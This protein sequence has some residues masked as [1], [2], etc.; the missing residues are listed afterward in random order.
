M[1]SGCL[2]VFAEAFEHEHRLRFEGCALLFPAFLMPAMVRLKTSRV[3][4]VV[5]KLGEKGLD[6]G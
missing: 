5:L 2:A 1:I 3:V 4:A 6:E